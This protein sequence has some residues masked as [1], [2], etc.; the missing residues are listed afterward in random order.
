MEFGA[1][2][3]VGAGITMG[4]EGINRRPMPKPLFDLTNIPPV[5]T[6]SSLVLHLDAGNPSSYSGGSVWNDIS[7]NGFQAAMS[8]NMIANFTPVSAPFGYPNTEASYFN[9]GLN[10]LSRYAQ[11]P[12]DPILR[13]T[14]AITMEAF[15]Y[16]A[17]YDAAANY[18]MHIPGTGQSGARL[19]TGPGEAF[20]SQSGRWWQ[21]GVN[22]ISQNPDSAL[23]ARDFQAHPY[24][25]HIVG[26]YNGSILTTYRNGVASPNPR[27]YTSS[28]TYTPSVPLW[29]NG[30][31]NTTTPPA[32]N[33]FYGYFAV[34]RMYNRGLTAAEVKNNYDAQKYRYGLT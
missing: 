32:F 14:T 24:W 15:L 27:A 20:L 28:I 30:F 10:Q 8:T 31:S 33:G 26:T 25:V 19:I 9:M 34:F 16:H 5:I 21:F 23:D 29:I 18:I 13:P 17:A 7:G 2:V 11:I 12:Y 1:G 6:D 4:G 3:R 22:G